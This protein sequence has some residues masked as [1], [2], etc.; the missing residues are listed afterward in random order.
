MIS[1]KSILPLFALLLIAAVPSSAATIKAG[2]M[3]DIVVVQHAEFS[4]RYVVNQNGTIDY[5]LLSDA[6]VANTTTGELGNDLTL[7]L[8]RHI[9]NPLV[10]VSI[11][12]KPEIVMTVLGLVA[13]PGPVVTYAGATLQEVL[14]CAGGTV[15][16]IADLEHVRVIHKIRQPPLETCNLK[17]FLVNGD[18]EKL[19]QLFAGDIIV[20]PSLQK[21]A[22]VKCIGAVQKP[23]LYALEGKTT[24]FEMIYLAGGPAERADL[25]RVRRLSQTAGGKT[26]EEIINVQ[27][28]IDK[29]Q[30]DAIPMANEGDVIIVYSKWFDGKTFLTILNNTLLFIVTIQAFRGAFK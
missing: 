21:T 26:T 9:D 3:L 20:V 22:K 8:A 24:M 7:R 15:P 25:S 23:G 11:V 13:K 17:A 10:L 29:G 4:G 16:D 19:P 12:H 28:F 5:P 18:I 27:A 30:M 2:D 14:F 6:V 1:S